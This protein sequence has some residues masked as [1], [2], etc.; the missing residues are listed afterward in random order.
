MILLNFRRPLVAFVLLV[1]MVVST[2]ANAHLMVARHGT[3]N[4]MD[5][6]IYMVVSLPVSA[7]TADDN[8]DGRLSMTEFAQHRD[9]LINDIKQ[10][11]KLSNKQGELELHGIMVSPVTPHDAPK[12]PAEQLIVMGRFLAE[13]NSGPLFFEV[14]LFGQQAQDQLLKFTASHKSENIKH[15]FELTPSNSIAKFVL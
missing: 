12:D 5:G 4:Y 3:L 7:F 10:S 14:G 6:S 2:I 1:G 9:E 13:Q 8:G 11:V 15:Q